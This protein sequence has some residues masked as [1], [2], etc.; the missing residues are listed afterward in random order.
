MSSHFLAINCQSQSSQRILSL[1]FDILHFSSFSFGFHFFTMAV[2]SS[3][4]S[5]EAEGSLFDQVKDDIVPEHVHISEYV[6][7]DA[8]R[9][10]EVGSGKVELVYVLVFVVVSGGV[11]YPVLADLSVLFI[12]ALF[13]KV[14]VMSY[15]TR[16]DLHHVSRVAFA[17]FISVI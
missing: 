8:A 11:L 14:T 1:D 2:S 7:I 16:F 5:P 13:I 10:L 3:V 4:P 9:F 17:L 6:N 15:E 12:S